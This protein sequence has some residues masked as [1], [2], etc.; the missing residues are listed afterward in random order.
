M[1][2]ESD[3]QK[4]KHVEQDQGPD[5]VYDVAAMRMSAPS[6]RSVKLT[7][8][9]ARFVSCVA[10]AGGRSV[11]R[12]VVLEALGDRDTDNGRRNLDALVSRL[13]MKVRDGTGQALPI[14]TVQGVGFYATSGLSLCG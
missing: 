4:K 14:E 8:R 13:R 11:A 7:P 10:R 5:W 2:F 1:S 3:S 9:E 12:G 6:G